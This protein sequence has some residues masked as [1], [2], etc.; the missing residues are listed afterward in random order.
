M[1]AIAPRAAAGRLGPNARQG[2]GRQARRIDEADAGWS[3]FFLNI[4]SRRPIVSVGSKGARFVMRTVFFVLWLAV[5]VAITADSLVPKPIVGAV[6]S[7]KL[8][9]FAAYAVLSGLTWPAFGIWGGR[10]M[11]VAALVLVAF[12]FGIEFLQPLVGRQFSLADEAAN[13]LGVFLGILLGRL[14]RLALPLNT[15]PA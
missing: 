9:H 10:R 2:V 15:P 14:S 5:L 1:T 13:I 3:W 7:D 11:L 8:L 4:G 6:G 12:G